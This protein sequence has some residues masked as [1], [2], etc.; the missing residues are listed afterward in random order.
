MFFVP[1]PIR[2]TTFRFHLRIGQWTPIR[3]WFY[4]LSSIYGCIA[5]YL[6]SIGRSIYCMHLTPVHRG[7]FCQFLFRWI[8][9]YGSN[10]SAGKETGKTQICAVQWYGGLTYL[11]FLVATFLIVVHQADNC[12]VSREDEKAMAKSSFFICLFF[13]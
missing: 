4:D 2:S 13:C 7:A 1:C 12:I 9:Y 11:K 8:Y 3:I 10:K 6:R 5:F